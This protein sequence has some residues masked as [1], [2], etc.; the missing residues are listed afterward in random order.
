MRIILGNRAGENF[1]PNQ[2][3]IYKIYSLVEI[4]HELDS[5]LS[6]RNKL[7]DNL[8]TDTVHQDLGYCKVTCVQFNCV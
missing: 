5:S 7:S 2:V 6:S 8:G 1:S 4:V 3:H